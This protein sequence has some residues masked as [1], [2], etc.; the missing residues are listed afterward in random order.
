MKDGKQEKADAAQKIQRL[1]E[2]TG[3][4]NL[5]ELADIINIKP[6]SVSGAI[7]RGKIPGDW[8]EKVATDYKVSADWLLFGEGK[9]GQ[10]SH[11]KVDDPGHKLVPISLI[12]ER[13][14]SEDGDF[15][16]I[17]NPAGLFEADE[18]MVAKYDK[19]SLLF[20]SVYDNSMAPTVVKGD[21]V[22]IDIN[23]KDNFP[24]GIYAISYGKMIYIRR[25]DRG[26]EKWIFKADQE[27]YSDV[28]YD[29]NADEA[30][31]P[32]KIR[33]KVVQWI[34]FYDDDGGTVD[35]ATSLPNFKFRLAHPPADD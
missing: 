33:G 3:A 5:T 17:I 13:L 10:K 25:L 27:G 35:I 7:K 4:T 12:S 31:Q 9:A 32:V 30:K 20:M 28:H 11:L 18:R 22:L 15:F 1:Q 24:H 23:N 26:P 6:Q 16:S 2:A 34:H 21:L 29:P 8:I 19:E 14:V